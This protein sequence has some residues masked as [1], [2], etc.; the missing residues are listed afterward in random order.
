MNVMVDL[1]V[2]GMVDILFELLPWFLAAVL[3]LGL[4]NEVFR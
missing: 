4:L 2:S 3:V 1:P